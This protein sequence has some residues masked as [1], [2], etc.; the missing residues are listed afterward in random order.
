MATVTV[1]VRS[2]GS[3]V[4]LDVSDDG[5]G[6]DRVRVIEQ[7]RARGLLEADEEPSDAAVADLI[8]HPGLST[9]SDV[10]VSS[11]R[12]VGLH[13][14]RSAVEELG[15]GVEFEAGAPWG[16]RFRLSVPVTLGVMR[17]LLARVGSE[18]YALPLTG[19]V[20]TV[21]IDRGRLSRLA[22]APV[23]LRDDE[24]VPVVDLG[25]AL[26]VPGDRD[27]RAGVLVRSGSESLVW[28]VDA[29]E[30][31]VE[32]VVKD[33]GGFLGRPQGLAGATLAPD[34][35]ILLL[36]DLRELA[37][38]HRGSTPAPLPQSA[39]PA[40]PEAPVETRPRVLVV[41]DSIGVR[42]LERVVLES[43]GYEVLTAVDGAEGARRLGGAPVDA[44]VSD[45]EMP[46]MDGFALTRALRATRGWEDVPVVIMTS[47]GDEADRRAGMDA[48]ANAY[49][50]KSEFDQH[51]LVETVRRLVGR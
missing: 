38:R 5:R 25:A 51:E 6:L 36:V 13:A 3:I 29:L 48:G 20:E 33:L 10:T 37:T 11:G 23:L 39:A 1:A 32:V 18:R 41:E 26:E 31:E 40:R 35:R 8:F 12:G 44:V 2:A 30:G 7:A 14:V 22:G 4:E 46:G 49:L 17:C 16:S 45:V 15:G 9:R 50:L 19:I 42:E 28:L 34:G 27:P 24:P 47:R 21:A 43:A